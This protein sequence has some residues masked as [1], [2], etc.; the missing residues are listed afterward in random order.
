MAARADT[1]RGLREPLTLERG[2]LD[3]F[4]PPTPAAGSS[5]SYNVAQFQAPYTRLLSATVTIATDANAANRVVSLQYVNGR[6][7]VAA[8]FTPSL[9]LTANTS[10][11]VF[12]WAASQAV[13]EW[14]TGTPIIVPLQPI[15]LE[16]GWSIGVSISGIQ[17][18][19]TITAPVFLHE[20]FYADYPS[21]P[22]AE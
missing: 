15:M 2:Y 6:T 11:T 1:F 10:Q 21:D 19:D 9:V 17:A 20:H 22:P 3:P 8:R 14:A 13:A 4:V 16:T 18:G 12:R 7:L 5:L